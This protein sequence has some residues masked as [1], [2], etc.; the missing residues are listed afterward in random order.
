M[1]ARI[2]SRDND[3]AGKA[4]AVKKNG[5]DTLSS[6]P[7]VHLDDEVDEELAARLSPA[8]TDLKMHTEFMGMP[9]DFTL[10]KAK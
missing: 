7:V 4:P 5:H 8:H 9:I 6:Q 10:K 2:S 1:F 3:K